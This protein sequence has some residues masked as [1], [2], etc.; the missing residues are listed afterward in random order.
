LTKCARCE[1]A[2][3]TTEIPFLTVAAIEAPHYLR[4]S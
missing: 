2:S 4:M 3:R 1:F